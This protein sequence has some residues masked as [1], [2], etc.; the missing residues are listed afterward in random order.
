MARLP[1]L[2][3]PKPSKASKNDL[4]S[5]P[6]TPPHT[7]SASRQAER[8]APKLSALKTTFEDRRLELQSSPDGIDPEQVLVLETV[9]RVD[10]FYKAVSRI[11]E[12]DWLGEYDVDQIAPD[13]DFFDPNNPTKQLGGRVYL[14]MSNQRALQEMLSLWERF[15]RNPRMKFK[16]AD[17][18]LAKIK[19]VFL[20]LRDIRRWGVK[21][22]LLEAELMT[23]WLEDLEH[24]STQLV[25]VEIELWFRRTEQQ[26]GLAEKAVAAEVERLDGK[27][28]TSSMV[29]EI[30]YHGILAELP[31]GS[32][33]HL[34][35]DPNVELVKNDAI[36]LFRPTG[37]IA[38]K[39]QPQT[40]ELSTI[41]ATQTPP[42][43]EGTPIVAV[44]DGCPLL[45]HQVLAN[46][47]LF[48]DPDDFESS[49]PT[50]AR[51]HGTAMCSLVVRGD[52]SVAAN[53][54]RTPIYQRPILQPWQDHNGRWV[55]AVPQRVLLVDLI[56][57]AV[58]RIF[59]SE[60]GQAAV[61][62]SV[63]VINLSIGDPYR[64]F[65]HF[66]SP[67][68][69]L[70]DWLSQ[71]YQVLF[72][73]S[74][75]NH[76]RDF[77]PGMSLADFR[78][79]SS[80]DKERTALNVLFGD[81]RNRRLL[82]PAESVNAI[83]VGATHFDDSTLTPAPGLEELYQSKL[84]SPVSAFGSGYRRAIKPDVVR[85]GGRARY[86][87][88]YQGS[89]YIY[90]SDYRAPGIQ[91]AAPSP[92]SGDLTR[93]VF[94]DGT[95]NAAALLSH[96]LGLCYENLLQIVA[97]NSPDTELDKYGSAMLKALAVHCSDWEGIGPQIRDHIRTSANANGIKRTVS[98]WIGYGDGEIDR[99]LE[100]TPQ[101]ATAL[102]FGELADGNAHLYRFPLPVELGP[103]TVYRTLRV[104]LAWFTPVAPTTQRYRCA[105]LWFNVTGNSFASKRQDAHGNSVTS[106][107][108]QHEVFG[109]NKASVI[110]ED[111]FV[112][113]KVN[114]KKDVGQDFGAIPYGLAVTLE[115]APGVNIPIYE[116][117]SQLIRPATAVRP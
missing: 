35:N 74:A 73:I 26:R 53:Y 11:P 18:G 59:E 92:N 101:R 29:P 113:I 44:L 43:P 96:D 23:G 85:P 24:Y 89:H 41:L 83:T 78:A 36:M 68:A 42:L 13:E 2:F 9:G 49:Y 91:V 76:A 65:D 22:R 90:N 31:R 111:A 51:S 27:V 45:N 117:V 39:R 25:D 7:P 30:C 34:I 28:I 12:L 55:E 58:R 94:T 115:V 98:R 114:C 56:H 15:Q 75:G 5:A 69:K 46:R 4:R 62:P 97:D 95:S 88:H 112:E 63:K 103:S 40:D 72:V 1:L 106:G 93:S 107:T 87:K 71:K 105:Y 84:G 100:C 32:V 60:G 10:Q 67:L 47:I 37:Q 57:R 50:A 82:S 20:L 110:D 81:V 109:G 19:S 80:A 70:L 77:H 48:D 6:I 116:R 33:D 61:A 38:S 79:L 14:M 99:V 102:G 3:F 17:Y 108:V 64:P 8:L 16:G 54:L 104:T 66:L 52:L 86:T 21:D